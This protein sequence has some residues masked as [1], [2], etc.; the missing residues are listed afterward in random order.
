MKRILT[1]AL[2]L[3]AGVMMAILAWAPP[4]RAALG[5]QYGVYVVT[6]VV[7]AGGATISTAGGVYEVGSTAGAITVSGGTATNPV[8]LVVTG[9]THTGTTS[10]L[11]LTGTANVVLYLA[12]GTSTTYACTGT[13]NSPVTTHQAGVYVS[14]TS[15][16]TIDG[17]GSLTANGGRYAAGIGGSYTAAANSNPNDLNAPGTINILNGNV[18][19]TGGVGGAGIG[20][21]LEGNGG[22]INI[23]GG[24]IVAN[25]GGGPTGTG[26]AGG[27]GG[28]GIGGGGDINAAAGTTATNWTAWAGV[29][30]I[31]GGNIT[32]TATVGSAAIGGGYW[33]GDGIIKIYGGTINATAKATGAGIGA[34]G[35]SRCGELFIFGGDITAVGGTT[36]AGLG[37]GINRTG[38]DLYIAGG[39]IRATG[40]TSANAG[41]IGGG[42]TS[43][44]MNIVGGNVY[45]AT[46]SGQIRVN[47]S[48]TNSTNY[49][50][51]A[52]Y[53]IVVTLLDANGNPLPDFT[54]S[55]PVSTGGY[56]Y[57]YAATTDA[58]GNAYLWLPAGDSKLLWTDDAAGTYTDYYLRV[59]KPGNV[60][61][62]TPVTYTIQMVDDPAWTLTEVD[63][64]KVYGNGELDL[65]INHNNPCTNSVTT[66]CN[67]AAITGVKWYREDV[68]NPTGTADGFDAG[69]TNAAAGNAGTDTGKGT[70]QLNLQ[71]GGTANSKTFHMPITRNGRYWVQTHY[72][73][74]NT[75]L[76]VYTVTSIDVSNIYTPVDVSV[77]DVNTAGNAVMK[78]YT[79]LTPTAPAKQVGIPFDLD[80]SVLASPVDGFD[81]LT[82]TRND[83]AP[84]PRWQMTLPSAAF[85]AASGTPETSVI[86]LDSAAVPATADATSTATSLLYTVE[87][88]DTDPG[89]TLTISKAVKGPMADTTRAFDF[90]IWLQNA[91]GPITGTFDC[92]DQTGQPC[93]AGPVVVTNGQGSFTL[94]AGQSVTLAEVPLAAE[95]QITEATV[96]GWTPSYTDSLDP[97]TVVT[98]NE[99]PLED[100]TVDRVFA[101][102]NTREVPP[103]TALRLGDVGNN[104]VLPVAFL[105]L[106]AP[107]YLGVR[108][109]R[110]KG[111][112]S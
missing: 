73:A 52:V 19:A 33:S 86:T 23:N 42:D 53:G 12:D 1:T 15:T 70:D 75:D 36:G 89:T 97:E 88:T 34:G 56:T 80:G 110:R 44:Y 22:T 68:T 92:T 54:L 46:S 78:D 16:L 65:S 104:L 99:T 55:V 17:T 37:N 105:A 48:P 100:M 8:V 21:G 108:A 9:G 71:A 35:G 107:A 61:S 98:S 83:A 81:T 7:P 77:R 111:V 59:T 63:T 13:S 45:A 3:C 29:I 93:A 39:N 91:D 106:L 85:S 43:S 25:G 6:S 11:A 40:G 103:A 20:G 58:S 74:M 2:A 102:V 82:Y 60:S 72:T 28:A 5:T 18:T 96:M 26:T 50:D 94:T 79:T 112:T 57:N 87:Y 66:A 38:C 31:N 27:G 47:N 84:A 24:T 62:Y 67:S 69:F 49:D 51:S 101:Y 10:R 109:L 76:D 90:S 41:I 95:V 32:A 64:T 30:T 4:A 14:Y